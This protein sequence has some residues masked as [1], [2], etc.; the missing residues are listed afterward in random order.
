MA[1]AHSKL[2]PAAF[3]VGFVVLGLF[4][5]LGSPHKPQPAT[6]ANQAASL[7][8]SNASWGAFDGARL[9][10]LVRPTGSSG[11]AARAE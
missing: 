2:V 6:R 5:S 8:R 9:L 7:T 3:W 4:T 11:E 10:S 1:L